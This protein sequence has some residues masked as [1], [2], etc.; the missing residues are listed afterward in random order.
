MARDDPKSVQR[1]PVAGQHGP[2]SEH[3]CEFLSYSYSIINYH[4]YTCHL[5]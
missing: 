5:Q 4:Y 3:L 1:G 2:L